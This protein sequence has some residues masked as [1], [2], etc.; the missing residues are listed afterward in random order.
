MEQPCGSETCL[1]GEGL[2]S[3]HSLLGLDFVVEST[4]KTESNSMDR[5]LGGLSAWPSKWSGLSIS[6]TDSELT[7]SLAL[8]VSEHQNLDNLCDLGAQ[9]HS[10]DATTESVLQPVLGHV[11]DGAAVSR[12]VMRLRVGRGSTR[13]P[14]GVKSVVLCCAFLCRLVPV[15]SAAAVIVAS[16]RFGFFGAHLH[17]PADS[18]PAFASG[19]VAET[20]L[21]S[22]LV[23]TSAT[24][25]TPT[26]AGSAA[27]DEVLF[28]TT[29][30]ARWLAWAEGLAATGH[31]VAMLDTLQGQLQG[32]LAEQKIAFEL[33]REQLTPL[34]HLDRLAMAAP[35]HPRT[36]PPS[37]VALAATLVSAH[38]AATAAAPAE[39]RSRRDEAPGRLERMLR[40]TRRRHWAAV[41]LPRG[42]DCTLAIDC[43]KL[44]GMAYHLSDDGAV[45]SQKIASDLA[46]RGAKLLRVFE[47]P[48]EETFAFLAQQGDQLTL[49]F[50]G[51]CTG[52]NVLTDIDYHPCSDSALGDF[53]A[54]SRLDFPPHMQLHRGF[55]Q[56]WRSLRS[57]I[58]EELEARLLSTDEADGAAARPLSLV[59]TG[60]SMGG[61]IAMLASLEVAR[62]LQEPLHPTAATTAPTA[63]VTANRRQDR[64]AKR[65]SVTTYT[66]A[67]PRLGNDA[68]AALFNE[69]FP[70]AAAHWALQHKADAIPHLPFAAWGFRHP[71]GVLKLG[72]PRALRR[73][74]DEG[75]AVHLLRPKAGAVHNWATCHDLAAYLQSLNRLLARATRPAHPPVRRRERHRE[76]R[77]ATKAIASLL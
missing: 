60:H 28:P 1:E 45:D 59:V 74:G 17:V 55:L 48:A 53:K 14:P 12:R 67:A 21:N 73:T 4:I 76:R 39:L 62:R 72:E 54:E 42:F 31:S 43:A 26:T 2:H 77:R 57:P 50:R 58:L 52:R 69:A 18:P 24:T 20:Y 71:Q 49:V 32:S 16:G 22:A 23:H 3:S 11:Q 51:S 5:R 30:K 40:R 46:A 41:T 13:P 10:N 9:F 56:A 47:S 70:D 44:S 64:R 37:A 38:A 35:S 68:F 6:R 15:A 36:P 66:F 75:D 19:A 61:A 27:A 7:F 33:L 8:S 34:K 65:T 25:G 29:L 63:A